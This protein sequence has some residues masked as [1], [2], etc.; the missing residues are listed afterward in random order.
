MSIPNIPTGRTENYLGNLIGQETAWEPGNPESRVEEYLDYILENGTK[1]E[2]EMEDEIESL[3]A[4][5][6]FLSLWNATTGL[7]TTEPSKLP[8]KYKAGD[9]YIVSVVGLTNYQPTGTKY[10]GIASSTL[11]S[12]DLHI[13]DFFVYDGSAWTMLSHSVVDTGSTFEAFPETWPTSSSYTT[14]QFCAVVNADEDAVQGKGYLGEVRWSDLPA[15]MV[16][17]EVQVEIMS[18]TGTSNKII[19]LICTSGNQEPYRW[20]YT[21]WNNGSNV[22]GWIGFQ[23]K[24]T[25]GTNITISGNTISATDTTYTAGSNIDITSGAISVN[26]GASA[27]GKV[28]TANGSGGATWSD[29]TGI[30]NYEVINRP[31]SMPT[32]TATSSDFIQYDNKLYKKV[33][34]SVVP[35]TI[36]DL[37]DTTWRFGYILNQGNIKNSLCSYNLTGTCYDFEQLG[38]SYEIPNEVQFSYIGLYD[39]GGPWWT[40]FATSSNYNSAPPKPYIYKQNGYRYGQ[41]TTESLNGVSVYFTCHITGGSGATNSTVI[42]WIEAN[43]TL[44]SPYVTT[45]SYEEVSD[46][47]QNPMTTAG[48]IIVG[49][50]SGTPGRLAKG[51]NGKVLKMVS[52]AP[53]WADD[54]ISSGSTPQGNLLAADG[55]GS[56]TWTNGIPYLTTAPSAN[57]PDA[58]LK[59]VVLDTDPV[60]KYNGYLYIITSPDIVYS[61]SG[62]VL[63]ITKAPY[64]KSGEILTIG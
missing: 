64:T 58:G 42:S 46:G 36:T 22:S 39:Y 6:R 7:P 47:M 23:P 19:H 15:S 41:I 8:Y 50:S 2:Q 40:T 48:D 43:A 4:I 28:L 55:S 14:A 34:S 3:K 60:N 11:Y 13:N 32:A 52:G 45:Y 38:S 12:D 21:Y 30:T 37:T 18:G 24:L 9:Y 25:A 61:Q 54:S 27:S 26:S 20:E 51:T 57:N 63:T 44:I 56:V 59:I 33:V 31:N 16:N 62:E 5:G 10:E 53:A 49:G 29:P 17:A 35:S 1:L